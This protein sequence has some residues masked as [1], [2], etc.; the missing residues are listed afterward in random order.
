MRGRNSREC[1]EWGTGILGKIRNVGR[2]FWEKSGMRG[3]I[4]GKAWECWEGIPGKVRNVG[5][6][7]GK[8][9]GN[10]GIWERN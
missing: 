8:R 10:V 2:E 4:P 7:M 5:R 3:S 6:E 9:Y 1:Q